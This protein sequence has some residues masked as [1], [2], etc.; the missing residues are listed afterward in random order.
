MALGAALGTGVGF[1]VCAI[2]AVVPRAHAAVKAAMKVRKRSPIERKQMRKSRAAALRY[3]AVASPSETD[4]A[5]STVRGAAGRT[6]HE[7]TRAKKAIIETTISTERLLLRY[8]G[9]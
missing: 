3:A 2:A 9:L 7:A 8:D 6:N 1:A 5:V 4:C